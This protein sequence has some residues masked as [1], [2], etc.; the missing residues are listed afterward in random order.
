MS[1]KFQELRNFLEQAYP[2]LRGGVR[3]EIYPPPLYAQVISQLGGLLYFA[4]LGLLFGG[5]FIF[6][7][8]GIGQPSWFKWMSENKL[9]CFFGIFIMNSVTGSLNKTGAFEVYLEL[10]G[11]EETVF[12]K[13]QAM[14]FPSARD[15]QEGMASFGLY[16]VVRQ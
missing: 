6:S 15:I 14:T 7:T 11:Q 16:P 3:G 1:R 10:D 5:S 4:S 8:L 9:Q 13:L 12:S 2:E